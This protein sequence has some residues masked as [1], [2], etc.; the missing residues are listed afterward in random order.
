MPAHVTHI[1]IVALVFLSR[2]HND[3][4]FSVLPNIRYIVILRPSQNGIIKHTKVYFGL[5]Q[6]AV[7]PGLLRYIAAA[8]SVIYKN[9]VGAHKYSWFAKKVLCTTYIVLWFFSSPTKWQKCAYVYIAL[10]RGYEIYIASQKNLDVY[11]VLYFSCKQNDQ[12]CPCIIT[13]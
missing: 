8:G 3:A 9:V 13:K 5:H 10:T 7:A 11:I 4:R 2:I 1:F 12:W 6:L